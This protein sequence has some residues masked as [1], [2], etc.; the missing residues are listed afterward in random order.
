MFLLLSEK[1]SDLPTI[2]NDSRTD[3]DHSNLR[4]EIDNFES[5][6]DRLL[7]EAHEK[8]ELNQI[9]GL[10]QRQMR[11]EADKLYVREN[12]RPE[13]MLQLSAIRVKRDVNL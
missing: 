4:L 13:T 7:G 5:D 6:L 12:K 2:Q 1:N 3:L 10:T 11:H 8:I 9:S